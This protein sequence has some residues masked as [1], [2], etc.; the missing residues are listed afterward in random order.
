MLNK[1]SLSNIMRW[2]KGR[3]KYEIN[4]NNDKIYFAWQ[5]RFHD[6]IIRNEKALDNIREYIFNNPVNWETDRNNQDGIKELVYE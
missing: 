2:F 4:K 3:A 1:N 6:H 5:A